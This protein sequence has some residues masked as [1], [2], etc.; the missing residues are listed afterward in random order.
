MIFRIG[1]ATSK[2]YSYAYWFR[3]DPQTPYEL[4]TNTYN[5]VLDYII[6][7]TDKTIWVKKGN[8]PYKQITLEELKKYINSYEQA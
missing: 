6:E 3:D 2:N 5:G 8:K 7:L 4:L 1:T